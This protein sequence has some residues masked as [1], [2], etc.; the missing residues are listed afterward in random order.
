[1]KRRGF[2]LIE[3]LVVI[4][5]IAILAAILFPVF[6]KA[7]EKARQASCSSN[8]R[9]LGIALTMYIQ[10][11]DEELMQACYG[12]A[13]WCYTNPL[14]PYVKNAQIF[15]C[16]SYLHDQPDPG[17]C[18]SGWMPYPAWDTN[19]YPAYG[20]NCKYAWA[21]TRLSV[22]EEPAR[23]AVF[24]DAVNWPVRPKDACLSPWGLP[25]GLG[26]W[27]NE[28]LNI[29]FADGH[30]K[31]YKTSAVDSVKWAGWYPKSSCAAGCGPHYP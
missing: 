18:A 27:H 23:L 25:T 14:Y 15:Q 8:C 2:T 31:W 17:C 22:V 30:V 16:P 10:D 7:R 3:L 26:N 19:W 6:A 9:Q 4:A 29:V 11:Y 13:C 20:Y 1:M 28:G 24:C 21:G 5:I 12:G